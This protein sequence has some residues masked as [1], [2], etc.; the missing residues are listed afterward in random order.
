MARLTTALHA[1]RV[2][3]M[4]GGM[5]SELYQAGLEPDECGEDWNRSRPE[6][7]RDIHREYVEAGAQCL[8]TNTFQANP[9]ALVRHDREEAVGAIIRAGVRLARSAVGPEGFVLGDIGPVIIAPSDPDFSDW[10]D[11]ARV[12]EEFAG[13][14]FSWPGVDGLLLE[15]CSTPRALTA[16]EFIRHRLLDHADVP[17][18]LSLT[19]QCHPDGRI[20]TPGGQ[21]PETFARHAAKHGVSALGVNCGRDLDMDAL[22]EIVRRYRACCDLP[23]F[24][25]PNAGTPEVIDGHLVYPESPRS[26]AAK[27]LQLLEAGVSMVGGCCGTTP[28]HIAAFRTVVDQWNASR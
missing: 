22:V 16:V 9:C 7:V 13:P 14:D 21:T 28:A 15:T 10:D 12:V 1:S 18:L 19:Y 23:L 11:L 17:V 2:L 6:R 27:L 3:L 8:L 24:V 5:G 25:R 26:M 4:D 20:L